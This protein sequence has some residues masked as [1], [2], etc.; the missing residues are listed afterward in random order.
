M[1]QIYFDEMKTSTRLEKSYFIIYIFR[2][3]LYVLLVFKQPILS[4]QWIFLL[5]LNMA[6]FIY[7]GLVKP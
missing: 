4:L 3:M 7:L 5:Y 1:L 2:R 6:N